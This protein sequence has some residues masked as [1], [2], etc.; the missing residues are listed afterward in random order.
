MDK[1]VLDVGLGGA[2]GYE[3]QSFL[4]LPKVGRKSAKR[5]DRIWSAWFFFRFY[6]KPPLLEKSKAKVVRDTNGVSGFDNA[7][8]KLDFHGST[9]HGKHVHVD[10]QGETG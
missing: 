4:Q 6:F 2:Q 9:R 5:L 7:D 1:S 10:F 3:P 8:I